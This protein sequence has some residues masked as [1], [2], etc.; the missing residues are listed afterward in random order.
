MTIKELGVASHTNAVN[1]GFYQQIQELLGHPALTL[2]QRN[3]IR[4]LW[5]SNRLML[6]VS[7]L[8]EGL[9]GIRHGNLSSEPKSGGL[10]EELADA[11]IRLVDL[12]EDIELDLEAAV[13]AK[14]AFNLLR[15]YKHGNRAV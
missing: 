6:I 3:F 1:K 4:T 13:I 15:E 5:M 12:A 11:Q 10:G 14:A 7:E 8:A 9:E 2:E